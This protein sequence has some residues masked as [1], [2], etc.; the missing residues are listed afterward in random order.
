MTTSQSEEKEIVIPFEGFMVHIVYPEN[1][2]HGR[3]SRF[4]VQTGNGSRE[5]VAFDSLELDA[6]FLELKK[7]AEFGL[8]MKRAADEAVLSRPSTKVIFP[9]PSPLMRRIGAG[10]LRGEF[11]NVPPDT[12]PMT[13]YFKEQLDTPLSE[14]NGDPPPFAKD[15]VDAQRA[16]L[17]YDKPSVIDQVTSDPSA[18]ASDAHDFNGSSLDHIKSPLAGRHHMFSST[19]KLKFDERIDKPE[20]YEK[21]LAIATGFNP[22]ASYQTLSKCI[23]PACNGEGISLEAREFK[24]IFNQEV[25]YRLTQEDVNAMIFAGCLKDLTH[26]WNGSAWIVRK[27]FDKPTPEQVMEWAKADA[28]GLDTACI[29]AITQNRLSAFGLSMRCKPCGGSGETLQFTGSIKK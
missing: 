10:T 26:F 14:E 19:I 16:Q 3:P 2:I 28:V 29:N 20:L 21:P 17:D 1:Y 27:T 12:A 8:R 22:N 5:N 13:D 18:I 4:Y 25:Q 7:R 11:K 24:K 15:D 23:C 9:E 6:L